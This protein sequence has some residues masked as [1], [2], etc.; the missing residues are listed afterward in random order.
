[1]ISVI[2]CTYNR[3]ESLKKALRSVAESQLPE[4]VPWEVLIVDNNSKD[5][6]AQTAQEFCQQAPQRFRYIFE[7]KQGKSHALNTA[8]R[9]A[10]GEILAFMDDDVTVEPTWLWNLTNCLFEDNYVGA[11]GRILP[12]RSF[13][14]PPWLPVEGRYALAPL[15]V[16]DLGT[17]LCDLNEPPFGTNMAFKKQVFSKYGTFRADLGP[18]PGSEI[19]DE[20]TEF[21][22]RLLSAG[23]RLRYVGT[24][25]VYHSVSESRLK[26]SFFLTWSFDK[27]RAQ[28]REHGAPLQSKWI[29][30]GVPLPLFRR[31]AVWSVRWMCTVQPSRRFSCKLNV[32]GLAGSILESFRTLRKSVRPKSDKWTSLA[33]ETEKHT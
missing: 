31:F 7:S 17:D 27:A 33:H 24:A 10:K 6:T 14:P 16:F 29:V 9:E 25:V 32:W 15:V 11:G 13:T 22:R 8:I 3:A 28:V 12:E 21:G 19:R 23:E 26:K 18:R 20:D 4:S 2:V 30:A 1:M 5:L